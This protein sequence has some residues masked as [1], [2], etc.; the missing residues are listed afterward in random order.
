[1]TAI[2]STGWIHAKSRL[3][4]TL[5]IFND[6]KSAKYAP[7]LSTKNEQKD[8]SKDY[9]SQCLQITQPVIRPGPIQRQAASD[10]SDKSEIEK[11]IEVTS[12]D[13][14][15]TVRTSKD[16]E[17][18]P[19]GP[20]RSQRLQLQSLEPLKTGP[21]T[22]SMSKIASR[23]EMCSFT[24]ALDDND[25]PE[26]L[27]KDENSEDK[28]SDFN[29]VTISENIDIAENHSLSSEEIHISEP[30]NVQEALKS[31]IWKKI[32]GQQD[33][34]PNQLEY[35]GDSQSSSRCQYSW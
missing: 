25:N 26:L 29:H 3:S 13:D 6:M 17:Q 21:I 4:I 14:Q 9:F 7:I 19:M 32:N 15:T 22:L 1:V 24:Y 31:P 27:E 34:I 28:S 12:E 23:V 33:K 10:T 8:T 2:V 35:M 20:R 16:A 5:Y 11:Q 18:V 30:L